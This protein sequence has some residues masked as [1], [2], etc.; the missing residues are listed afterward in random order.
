MNG[1][2]P[3]VVR[4]EFTVEGRASKGSLSS[5]KLPL[6]EPL[7]QQKELTVLYVPDNPRVNTVYLD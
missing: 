2:N 4:W 7:M 1:R 3:L 5:M 6:I